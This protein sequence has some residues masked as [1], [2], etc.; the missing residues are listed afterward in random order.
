MLKR[1]CAWWEESD[2]S[3]APG[4]GDEE[5]GKDVGEGEEGWHKESEKESMKTS[6]GPEF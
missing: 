4:E 5:E 6:E 3:Y 2:G 1:V